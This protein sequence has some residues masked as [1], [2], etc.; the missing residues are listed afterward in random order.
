[1]ISRETISGNTT[2][3]YDVGDAMSAGSRR[4][5]KSVW[6][7]A[8]LVLDPK[9]QHFAASFEKGAIL[10]LRLPPPFAL[11]ALAVRRELAGFGHA[12]VRHARRAATYDQ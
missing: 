4:T 3:A 8:F 10:A 1:M 2:T 11:G 9:R 12:W 5:A 6:R 7:D